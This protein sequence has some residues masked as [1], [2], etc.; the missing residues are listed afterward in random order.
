MANTVN[1]EMTDCVVVC[2]TSNGLELRG[3]VLK[4]SR[5]LAV[6]EIYNS[7]SLLRLSEVL[8]DFKIMVQDRALY[9]GRA[10]VRGLIDA[11][12]SM[13]CEAT[14]EDSWL[15]IDFF[16][17]EGWESRLREDYSRFMAASQKNFLILPEFKVAVADLQMLLMDLRVWLEQVELGVRAQPTNNRAEIERKTILELQESIVMTTLQVLE[18]FENAALLVD[19]EKRAAHMRYM[20]RQIHPLVL[21]APFIHRTFYKPLG[22]AG[23]Y[24][25]VDM[26]IRDPYEGASI[27]AKLLNRVFLCTP[28]VE[29]HRNRLVY[30]KQLLCD[31]ALRTLRSGRPATVFNL[32]CGPAREIQNFLAQHDLCQNM[33]FTLLDFNEET[34]NHTSQTL[35]EVIRRHQRSTQVQIVKKSVHQ[36]LREAAKAHTNGKKYDFVYCAGLFDYLSD[37][38]CRHLM[39]LFYELVAPGGLL[40]ATNVADLNPS[41]GWMEYVLDW[42]LV[43]RSPQQFATLAPVTARPDHCVVRAIGDAVNISIEVRK[44]EH[45]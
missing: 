26:M 4:L 14:L 18:R 6:F 1:G 25:M 7:A 17:T 20:K 42:N 34:L 30:L 28:P 38:V 40:I 24:E 33:H 9:S 11:G 45:A 5:F 13:V 31:E 36:L 10:V 23:D 16:S 35:A 2:K 37:S 43:Y 27:F 22:Y 21:C 41:R 12:P 44:P 15:D 19:P 39:N 32:G 29:A 8:G 3:T